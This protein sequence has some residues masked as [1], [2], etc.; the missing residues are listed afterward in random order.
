MS[1]KQ[2]RNERRADGGSQRGRAVGKSA[3]SPPGFASFTSEASA[4]LIEGTSRYLPSQCLSQCRPSLR[5]VTVIIVKV[6]LRASR[7]PLG[8]SSTGSSKAGV[9]CHVHVMTL[10][11]LLCF[12][13]LIHISQSS[14]ES[15]GAEADPLASAR[16]TLLRETCLMSSDIQVPTPRRQPGAPRQPVGSFMGRESLVTSCGTL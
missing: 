10:H 15:H 3:V 11:W 14:A 1:T 13:F 2:R 5:L 12:S 9:L 8:I 6:E 4:S 16:P 7:L